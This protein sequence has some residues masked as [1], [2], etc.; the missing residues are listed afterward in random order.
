MSTHHRQARFAARS[1]RKTIVGVLA[2]VLAA[3]MMMAGVSSAS[4]DSAPVN[5][6][7]PKTPVTVTADALPTVQIDGVVW[8]QIV[9]GDTVYAAGS[10]TTARPA[11]SPAGVN[12]VTRNNVLA[13]DIRTGELIDSFAPDLNGEAVAI[14]SSPDGSRIYVGGSFTSVNGAKV[15]RVAALDAATGAL[16]PSFAPK[17]DASVR[18]IVTVG[19]RVYLGGVFS[20]VGTVSRS[21]LAAFDAADATLLEWNPVANTGRV[22]ALS[23]SPDGTKMVVGG[24]FTTLNGS[25][26]PGF[27]LGAVDT[28]AGASLPFP[29]NDV[30]RNGSNHGSITSL[31]SDGTFVY[32]SGYTFGRT[33][34]LEGVFSVRWSDFST[35]WIQDCH[36]DTYSVY[37]AEQ[38]VYTAGHAHYCGNIGGFPQ[39]NP[40]TFNRALAFS[41]QATQTVTADPHGYTSYTGTPAPSLLTWFPSIIDGTYTGQSQGAWS[42]AGNSEYVVMGGEFPV[43]NGREQQGL[44]RFAAR[45]KAPNL[46]GPRVTG[47]NF[48]PTLVSP[49]AG[50]V[51]VR[52][53]ANWD[54]DN[55]NLTYSVLRDAA[56]IHTTSQESTFGNAPQWRTSTPG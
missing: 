6:A 4:A 47:A 29:I 42:V 54:Q 34:T 31:T 48:N 36:G 44:V 55:K 53:Q 23:L 9:V 45:D 27:G 25:S 30:V 20:S 38:V 8:Q 39:E 10:F 52:W 50:I 16:I 49:A 24:T 13:Y 28:V 15:W 51:R 56:T 14:A 41:K 37:A 2:G 35:N 7:D 40:W 17:M 5:P 46:R 33:S 19:D 3:S 1:F 32:G 22:N 43:V 18:A 21:K 11:G 26:R 12:T